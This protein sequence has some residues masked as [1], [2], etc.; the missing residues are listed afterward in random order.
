MKY[1]GIFHLGVHKATLAAAQV[2]LGERVAVTLERDDEPLP[3]DVVPEDLAAALAWDPQA[4][5]AFAKLRPSLRREL[6]KQLVS[7]KRAETRARRLATIL[8]TLTAR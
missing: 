6:V 7:A 4:A 8:Q 5:T 1:S 2:T 3:M